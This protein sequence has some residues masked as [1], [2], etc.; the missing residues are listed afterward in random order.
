[1]RPKY[2]CN[3]FWQLFLTPMYLIY[4]WYHGWYVRITVIHR[5]FSK[6]TLCNFCKIMASH[7]DS[8]IFILIPNINLILFSIYYQCWI[9]FLPK[10]M[11]SKACCVH[12]KRKLS[13]W[14]HQEDNYEWQW[15]EMPMTHTWNLFM[16]FACVPRMV[17]LK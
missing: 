14:E 1:V 17:S 13:S 4:I 11:K 2:P 3:Y 12:V 10:K 5:N 15:W 16:V 6:T 9:K 8:D 7:F